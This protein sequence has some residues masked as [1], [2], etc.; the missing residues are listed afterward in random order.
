MIDFDEASVRAAEE[1]SFLNIVEKLAVA[2]L[3]FASV[4]DVLKDVNGLQAFAAGSV[5]LR[6]GDQEGAL[7]HRVYVFIG[8]TFR[9]TT[10]GTRPRRQFRACGQQSSNI[11]PDQLL[12]LNADEICQRP[13]DAQ[14][15][16]RLIVRDDE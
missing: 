8:Q 10:K 12:R 1:Q 4:G 3:G 15:V 2:A 13:I 9:V 6:G 5:H 7:E 16:P 14:D 11:Q